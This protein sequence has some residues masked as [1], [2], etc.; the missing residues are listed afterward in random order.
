MIETHSKPILYNHAQSPILS[1]GLCAE[2]GF[3]LDAPA[4]SARSGGYGI[5]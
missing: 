4:G 1:L 3:R 2:P 5:G